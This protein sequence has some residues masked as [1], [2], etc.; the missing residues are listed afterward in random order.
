MEELYPQLT[1]IWQDEVKRRGWMYRVYLRVEYG[2]AVAAASPRWMNTGESKPCLYAPS[3]TRSTVSLWTDALLLTSWSRSVKRILRSFYRIYH[4]KAVEAAQQISSNRKSGWI[5]QQTRYYHK[6]KLK[7]VQVN[8][9]DI[10][11]Q[12]KPSQVTSLPCNRDDCTLTRQAQKRSGRLGTSSALY[13][14]AHPHARL[15]LDL[16]IPVSSAFRVSSSRPSV[17]EVRRSIRL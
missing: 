16:Q 12:V 10:R 15:S 5:R 2:I 13:G 11:N 7:G 6:R 9:F 8:N 3:A 1:G 14:S 4:E 17:R